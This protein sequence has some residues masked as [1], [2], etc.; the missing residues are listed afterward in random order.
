ME[1]I[2]IKVIIDEVF[3]KSCDNIICDTCKYKEYCELINKFINNIKDKDL[4]PDQYVRV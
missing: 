2:N 1:N 3:C 4:S